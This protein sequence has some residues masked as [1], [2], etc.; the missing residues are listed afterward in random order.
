MYSGVYDH[1]PQCL[2]YIEMSFYVTR[3]PF[4]VLG[5]YI[6]N[7][8]REQF[9]R[10]Q[11]YL[12]LIKISHKCRHKHGKR[13][14]FLCYV[15]E[16]G[17]LTINWKN[18]C[19]RGAFLASKNE[20]LFLLEDHSFWKIFLVPSVFFSG[21][22]KNRIPKSPIWAKI[23]IQMLELTG[24]IKGKPNCAQISLLCKLLIQ[25]LT[26]K[27]LPKRQ[28]YVQLSVNSLAKLKKGKNTFCLCG[29][30]LNSRPNVIQFI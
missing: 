27:R 29:A 5:L 15:V 28:S 26:L 12:S 20:L 17:K 13:G 21:I 8:P 6:R 11:I 1:Y 25:L 10:S 7:V 9:G 24:R 4:S 18:M 19:L 14:N 16:L 30:S 22:R 3:Y 2:R 23:K